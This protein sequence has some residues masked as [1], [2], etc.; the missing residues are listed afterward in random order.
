MTAFVNITKVNFIWGCYTGLNQVAALNRGVHTP[1]IITFSKKKI[2]VKNP[3]TSTKRTLISIQC[4]S[5]IPSIS[6]KRTNNHLS[7]Q[8]IE[9][10][11]TYFFITM[12][13]FFLKN[14]STTD[15]Y[16]VSFHSSLIRSI[17][18]RTVKNIDQ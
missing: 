7:Q 13:L 8:F 18:C 15:V 3:P 10:K 11:K 4:W 6:T 17:I 16:Q 1:K 12:W 9:H 2:M 14:P 5:T